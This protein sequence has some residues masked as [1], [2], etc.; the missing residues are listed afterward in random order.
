MKW[1]L[2]RSSLKFYFLVSK[3][4][5]LL[6]TRIMYYISNKFSLIQCVCYWSGRNIFSRIILFISTVEP[7]F[8]RHPRDR[9]KCHL[10]KG[11]PWREVGLRQLIINQEI[12]HSKS[13][14]IYLYEIIWWI[15][16]SALRRELVSF[17][18]ESFYH[19]DK[20]AVRN[21]DPLC[22]QSG[23]FWVIRCPLNG[24]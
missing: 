1:K 2:A 11:V 8:R 5:R 23:T 20:C 3:N 15:H 17:L 6:L 4:V 10:N 13:L 24:G 14:L 9:V 18:C 21:I 16:K 7:L 22:G 19:C 12:Q